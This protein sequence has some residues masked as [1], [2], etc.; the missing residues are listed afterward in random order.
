MLMRGVL[1]RNLQKAGQLI[2]IFI[3]FPSVYKCGK[4]IKK[5][6]FFCVSLYDR[7]NQV[8]IGNADWK[9]FSFAFIVPLGQIE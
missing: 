1:W 2:L 8:K 5:N 4:P 3:Y 7:H 6:W 9:E